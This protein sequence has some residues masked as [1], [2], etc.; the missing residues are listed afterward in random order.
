M[1]CSW[2]CFVLRLVSSLIFFVSSNLLR[3][4]SSS[5]LSSS[6]LRSHFLLPFFFFLPLCLSLSLSLSLLFIHS[7]FCCAYFVNIPLQSFLLSRAQQRA[8]DNAWQAEFPQVRSTNK[9]LLSTI[10]A[11]V[12]CRNFRASLLCLSYELHRE[13]R[14][15]R[16]WMATYLPY[17]YI[18]I[19]AR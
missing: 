9:W 1:V 4:S 19:T 12:V 6:L 14:Y 11:P 5:S 13:D 7:P 10:I 3:S 2:C 16:L 17:V 18:D 15:F 8:F